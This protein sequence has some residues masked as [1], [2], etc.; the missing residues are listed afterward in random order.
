MV[1]YLSTQCSFVAS[2]AANSFTKCGLFPVFS[3]CCIVATTM[4]SLIPSVSILLLV[5]SATGEGGG[6]NSL[7]RCGRP[8]LNRI[9]VVRGGLIRPGGGEVDV[10]DRLD[11]LG[12]GSASWM[13]LSGGEGAHRLELMMPRSPRFSDTLRV[14][15]LE[16]RR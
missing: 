13:T 15:M 14:C 12:S 4:S 2:T 5:P 7:A 16:Q 9:V 8:S 6:D 3:I 1:T 11:F 10:C